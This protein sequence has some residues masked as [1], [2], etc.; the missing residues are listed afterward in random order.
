[1]AVLA[2][3]L[4]P[5]TDGDDTPLSVWPSA[6]GWAIRPRGRKDRQTLATARAAEG[7]RILN[8]TARQ[9]VIGAQMAARLHTPPEP[10]Q[11]PPDIEVSVGKLWV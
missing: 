3:P 8:S 7:I 4:P 5:G 9:A 6:N 10:L 11:Q 2:P 1:M